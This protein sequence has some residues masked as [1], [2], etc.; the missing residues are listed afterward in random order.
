MTHPPSPPPAG[1]PP[2]P[3]PG[4]PHDPTQPLHPAQSEP[5]T[6]PLQPGQP[7]EPTQPLHPVPPAG[8]APG[9]PA[10]PPHPVSGQ[11]YGQPAANPYAQPQP[12][13]S[14]GPGYPPTTAYPAGPAYPARQYGQPQP[15]QPVPPGQYSQPQAGRPGQ[16]V[17][18][19]TP[20]KRSKTG[21]II[22]I[23]LVLLLCCGGVAVGGVFLVLRAKNGLEQAG[24]LPDL[25]TATAPSPNPGDGMVTVVYEV[26]G[27]GAAQIEYNDEGVTLKRE[28]DV[29]LPWRKEMTLPKTT[30][31]RVKG[32]FE[33]TD[34]G[35]ISC[36]LT[37]DGQVKQRMSSA[38][39]GQAGVV[40][41]WQVGVD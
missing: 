38:T 17:P 27:T 1:S 29:A 7:P 41:C 30:L 15:G 36:T 40:S 14:G 23:V 18:P 25:P 16:P 21:L 8:A 20:V 6:Q 28:H 26:T 32:Y 9:S 13:G 37:I 31:F 2:S 12:P 39:W 3:E 19:G 5:T 34:S 4:Q 11:P 10:A 35:D 22:G 33:G 24:Q